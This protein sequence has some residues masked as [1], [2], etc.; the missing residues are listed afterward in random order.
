[1]P[2]LKR[3]KYKKN[4]LK[5]TRE[6]LAGPFTSFSVILVSTTWLE[7]LFFFFVYF[8]LKFL[9]TVMLNFKHLNGA[10]FLTTCHH[11]EDGEP[12]V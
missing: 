2:L 6:S 7:Q 1:M 10:I 8:S 3:T 11:T 9:A 12:T 4:G 5:H